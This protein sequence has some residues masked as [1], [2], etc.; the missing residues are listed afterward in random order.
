MST[1][2]ATP[3]TYGLDSSIA[4]FSITR[5]QKM[6][7]TGILTSEDK[8]E[9]LENYVVLKMPRNP[10]HDGT[11]DLLKAA[12]PSLVP[13]GWLLR[14]QQTIV[15]ADSQPEPDFAIVRGGACTY[16]ARHPVPAD[17]A[18]VIEVADS[19]LLRDQRDKTRIYARAD[20]PCYWIVN[21]VDGHVE[22]YTQPTGPT[23]VP[24]YPSVRI[25]RRGDHVPL[26]LDGTTVAT[27]PTTDLLR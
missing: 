19:S 16:L 21:L 23:A 15:L 20:I 3:V 17:A 25:Y 12:L 26:V 18:L 27:I 9:L 8:V 1:A 6:I 14:I 4:R 2:A 13:A 22:V 11:I 7:E 5:Y 24:E 10:S